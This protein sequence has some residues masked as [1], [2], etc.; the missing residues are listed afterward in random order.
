MP[1]ARARKMMQV[2]CRCILGWRLSPIRGSLGHLGKPGLSKY[3]GSSQPPYS[4]R[5]RSGTPVGGEIPVYMGQAD[6]RVIFEWRP[7]GVKLKMLL[8]WMQMAGLS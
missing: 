3:P 1:R 4:E 7:Y 2:S 6:G 8:L 5:E